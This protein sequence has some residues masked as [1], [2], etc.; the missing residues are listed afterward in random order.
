MWSIAATEGV[1]A[2]TVSR[3]TSTAGPFRARR[4][5][6]PAE[7]LH[8]ARD[9]DWV[10]R[11]RSG[12]SV[13]SLAREAGVSRHV[14]TRVTSRWGP[15][16]RRAALDP[17]RVAEWVAARRQRRSVPAIAE[18]A[19]CGPGRVRAATAPWG[20][21]PPP[22]H[23]RDGLIGVQGVADLLGLAGPTVIRWRERGFL[24]A[25]QA[26]SRGGAG[27]WRPQVVQAWA[28]AAGL[29]TCPVCGARPNDLSRH[30]GARH[31][32]PR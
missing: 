18:E 21:F 7:E 3:A 6:P 20:P 30:H 29:A 31:R 11:R 26:S 10:E 13:A 17:D 12:W 1:G 32:H 28:D 5:R 9:A 27:L 15:Y 22:R 19:G 8:R 23:H 14:V 25:P 16:P 2:A 4:A 24:P